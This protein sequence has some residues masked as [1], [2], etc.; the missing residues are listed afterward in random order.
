VRARALS[1]LAHGERGDL[2]PLARGALTDAYLGARLAAIELADHAGRSLL[3]EAAVGSDL[4][5]AL[6]A[7][8]ALRRQHQAAPAELLPRALASEVWNVRAAAAAAAPDLVDAPT[9]LTLVAPIAVDDPIVEVRIAAARALAALGAR[10]KA[11]PVLAAAAE[12]GRTDSARLAAAIELLRLDDPRAAATLAALA[13]S[14]TPATRRG[15]A[16]AYRQTTRPG[17]PVIGALADD[18]AEVRLEAAETLL[19]LTR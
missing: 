10:D 5:V 19:Y 15:V 6:R 8:A 1:A 4:F 17:D 11:L 13:T 16:A 12:F 2:L 18:S 9:A 3:A 7:A 14:T